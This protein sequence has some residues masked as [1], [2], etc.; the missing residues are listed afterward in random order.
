MLEIYDVVLHADDNRI[1]R[2]NVSYHELEILCDICVYK[3][4]RLWI[5]F[6]ERWMKDKK[7]RLVHWKEKEISDQYQQIILNKVFEM[8]GLDLEKGLELKKNHLAKKKKTD[9]NKENT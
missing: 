8:V 1:G 7:I 5:R 3:Q 2:V 4:E 9:K 6:P